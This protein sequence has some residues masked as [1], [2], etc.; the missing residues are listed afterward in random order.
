MLDRLDKDTVL[1]KLEIAHFLALIQ[2]AHYRNNVRLTGRYRHEPWRVIPAHLR[3]GMA[4]ALY[5]VE[6]DFTTRTSGV[7]RHFVALSRQAGNTGRTSLTNRESC[8]AL[9]RTH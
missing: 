8:S 7:A 9:E 1:G 6:C 5:A 3:R 2:I 4:D